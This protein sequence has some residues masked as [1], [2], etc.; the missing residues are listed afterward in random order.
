MIAGLELL[1]LTLTGA[2]A[3]DEAAAM[4]LRLVLRFMLRQVLRAT[5]RHEKTPKLPDFA[6]EETYG[7]NW[8]LVYRLM[9]GWHQRHID[10]SCTVRIALGQST[11]SG[12]GVPCGVRGRN[13]CGARVQ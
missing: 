5:Q 13:A 2:F 7:L 9:G 10:W 4:L 6:Y 12:S 3:V 1:A 11:C 8:P